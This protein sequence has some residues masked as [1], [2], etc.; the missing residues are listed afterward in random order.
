MQVT[1][2]GLNLAEN[3]FQ[4]HGI[5]EDDAVDAE[6]IGEAVT[7]ATVYVCRRVACLSEP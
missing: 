4:V 3:V 7:R 5:A 2:V 1:A 6:A